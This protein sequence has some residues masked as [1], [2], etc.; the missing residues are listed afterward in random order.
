MAQLGSFCRN[1]FVDFLLTCSVCLPRLL[2][3]N[4]KKL[5]SLCRLARFLYYFSI[6]VFMCCFID[7]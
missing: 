1:Y 7:T 6:S 3:F 5:L 2:P 4:N